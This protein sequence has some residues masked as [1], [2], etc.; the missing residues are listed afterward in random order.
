MCRRYGA[1]D[2]DLLERIVGV[3]RQFLCAHIALC[4]ADGSPSPVGTSGGL[5]AVARNSRRTIGTLFREAKR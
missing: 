4:L 1:Y 3:F 5:G 2:I